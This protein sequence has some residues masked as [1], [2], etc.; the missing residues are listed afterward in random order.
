MAGMELGAAKFA[1]LPDCFQSLE[2][3]AV[4]LIATDGRLIKA[5]AGF[6][7]LIHADTPAPENVADNFIQ[8]AWQTLIGTHAPEDQPVYVGVINIGPPNGYCHSLLGMVQRRGSHLLFVGEHDI[9]ELEAL[10]TQV[11]K[12][13]E[14]MAEMQRELARSN[15]QL[16]ASEARFK[17]LS[18]TDP[19]TGLANRRHLEEQINGAI[20]RAQRYGETFSLILADIDH[21]KHIND[22]H[23]HDIGDHALSTFARL[24]HGQ[25]RD[26]DLAARVGGEE[27]V[28]LLP[29]AELSAATQSAE[30]LRVET[31][32]MR[33]TGLATAITAS[34]GVTRYQAGDNIHTLL[35]R[36]DQALYA[37]KNGGRDRVVT[38]D[39]A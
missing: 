18:I 14:Q 34:F 38:L 13:N 10:N 33:V 28:L 11:I 31:S 30:R 20:E 23:G 5:N 17:S 9:H 2:A 12:L 4:A 32:R 16:K 26:C 1:C 6:D 15:R 22:D 24:L 35:K 7:R 3:V 25:I 37:A 8:P 36:V 19:L 39:P 29:R 21:F 27:F